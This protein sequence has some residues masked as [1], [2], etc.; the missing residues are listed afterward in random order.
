[1]DLS[2]AILSGALLALSFP[3]FGSPACAWI[4][5]APLLVAVC[6]RSVSWRRAFFLGLL[7]GAIYFWGT[8]YWLVATMTSFGGLAT[9]LAVFAATLLVAYLSLFPAAFSVI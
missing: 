2:L 1:M 4:A 9:P 8:L 3:K 6:R 5:L 7:T